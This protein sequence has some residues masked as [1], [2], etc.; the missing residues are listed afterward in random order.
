M[1]RFRGLE[2][3]AVVVLAALAS[4]AGLYL[5]VAI[6]RAQCSRDGGQPVTVGW[7]TWCL[8]GSGWEVERG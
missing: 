1:G 6:Q 5:Q 8:V 7:Q 3:I 4:W 2:W